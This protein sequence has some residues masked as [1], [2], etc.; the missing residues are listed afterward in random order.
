M[1]TQ[2]YKY[3]RDQFIDLL[4]DETKNPDFKKYR[5]YPDY[6]IYQKGLEKFPKL[7]QDV[8]PFVDE[9]K[10]R[11][12]EE[13]RYNAIHPSFFERFARSPLGLGAIFPGLVVD[14]HS[15]DWQKASLQGSIQGAL[16]LTT[17]GKLPFELQDYDLNPLE[18]IFSGLYSLLFPLDA[19]TMFIGGG[20][21]GL[22]LKGA[23]RYGTKKVIPKM[24]SKNLL[25]KKGL[26]N[27]ASKMAAKYGLDRKLAG[28]VMEHMAGSMGNFM[29]YEGVK[30]GFSATSSGDSWMNGFMK[31]A[32]HGAMLGASLGFTGGIM[33]HANKQLLFMRNYKNFQRGKGGF[34]GY[35]MGKILSKQQKSTLKKMYSQNSFKN[36]KKSQIDSRIAWTGKYGQYAAEV[37]TFTGFG[38]AE[39]WYSTGELPNVER[40]MSDMFVNAGFIGA[41]KYGQNR[42]ARVQ[43]SIGTFRALYE[44]KYAEREA[45]Y[46]KNEKSRKNVRKNAG[47]DLTK[48]QEK[49][50]DE[51][52]EEN[53]INRAE[54]RKEAETIIGE[55]SDLEA[56]L[57]A[58]NKIIANINA[59]TPEA[60]LD[61]LNKIKLTELPIISKSLTEA[62]GALEKAKDLGATDKQL[63]EF[64]KDIVA[65]EESIEVSVK[66]QAER[67]SERSVGEQNIF[68]ERQQQA[69]TLDIKTLWIPDKAN[70]GKNK[71]VTI[72]ELD[73][74]SSDALGKAIEAKQE[75]L[76]TGQEKLATK[77]AEKLRTGEEL[78]EAKKN[79]AELDADVDAKGGAKNFINR[80]KDPSKKTFIDIAEDASAMIVDWLRGD[81]KLTSGNGKT[82]ADLLNFVNKTDPSKITGKD[83]KRFAE[84]IGDVQGRFEGTLSDIVN[85]FNHANQQGLIK[86]YPLTKK[87]AKDLW[88]KNK[89]LIAQAGEKVK[90]AAAEVIE[91]LGGKD[92]YD[93]HMVESTKGDTE[94]NI[95]ARLS[96]KEGIGLRQQELTNLKPENIVKEGDNYKI[97][98]STKE[99]KGSRAREIPITKKMYQELK[100]LINSKGI[101]KGES[102]FRKTVGKEIME[103]TGTGKALISKG[104]KRPTLDTINRKKAESDV[105]TKVDPD[106]TGLSEFGRSLLDMV[107]GHKIK[108]SDRIYGLTVSKVKRDKLLLNVRKLVDGEI[109]V[110]EFE[111][112]NNRIV[113]GKEGV[114]KPAIKLSASQKKVLRVQSDKEIE[115]ESTKMEQM[116]K[117]TSLTN[118][119]KNSSK[120]IDGQS[121]II[122]KL[123]S[124]RD[125]GIITDRQ[126]NAKLNALSKKFEKTNKHGID[127][128]TVAEAFKNERVEIKQKAPYPPESPAQESIRYVETSKERHK[129]LL[130]NPKEMSKYDTNKK[131]QQQAVKDKELV[132]DTL[133]G[134]YWNKDKALE[135]VDKW[136]KSHE[137]NLKLKPEQTKWDKEWL[138]NY[139]QV[140]ETLTNID[141]TKP[142]KYGPTGKKIDVET[143]RKQA[144]AIANDA[145]RRKYE[146]KDIID[147]LGKDFKGKKIKNLT[148]QDLLDYIEHVADIKQ[149]G[150]KYT[151]LKSQKVK[152]MKII[153]E[154]DVSLDDLTRMIQSLGI[155]DG[156]LDSIDNPKMLNRLQSMVESGFGKADMSNTVTNQVVD[157]AEGAGALGL[158]TN[159]RKIWYP[160]TELLYRFGGE[161]GRKIADKLLDFDVATIRKRRWATE[162][163][164]KARAAVKKAGFRASEDYMFMFMETGPKWKGQFTKREL[165]FIEMLNAKE[166]NPL[167]I[168][169]DQ[170]RDMYNMYWGELTKTLL[171]NTPKAERKNALK[172]LTKKHVEN[173]FTRRV[174]PKVLESI[175]LE[176][177]PIYGKLLKDNVNELA[178][179]KA[180]ELKRRK[181]E[182]DNSYN[183]RKRNLKESYNNYFK[184]GAKVSKTVEKEIDKIKGD[185]VDFFLLPQTHIKLG[186]LNERV[187]TLDRKSKIKN[188]RGKLVEVDSY[189]ESFD[190]NVGHYGVGMSK[191]L[192]TL[193]F[194]PEFTDLGKKFGYPGIKKNLFQLINPDSK[195]KNPG[196]NSEWAMYIRDALGEQL[197]INS[198]PKRRLAS[199]NARFLGKLSTLS[200]AMGLSSPTSG[201]KNLAIG[202]PRSI[203]HFGFSNTVKALTRFMADGEELQK[204]DLNWVKEYGSKQLVMEAQE[205]PFGLEKTGLT[206][207]RL[208]NF[209][210][211]TKTEGLNRIVS[212]YAGHMMFQSTLSAYKG[213]ASKGFLDAISRTP[214]GGKKEIER[215]WREVWKLSKK[216]MDFLKDTK[217]E[218]LR[219]GPNKE[220]MDWITIKVQHYSHVS[221]QGSTS[222]ALL[223]KW[224]SGQYTR[225]LTLFQRMAWSTTTDIAQNYIMPIVKTGNAMP[226][227][228]AMIGHTL[229]GA[230]LY[231]FYKMV[232]GQEKPLQMSDEAWQKVMPNLWRS[233]FFGLFGELANPHTSPIYDRKGS[234]ANMFSGDAVVARSLLEPVII[235]NAL[236]LAENIPIALQGLY[237]QHPTKFWH[238]AMSDVANNSIVIV[239]Q[240]ARVKNN[241][242]SAHIISHNKFKGVN[243]EFMREKGYTYPRVIM[244]NA[245]T[246]Y[247]KDLKAAFWKGNKAE[248]SRSYWNA[249]NYLVTELQVQNFSPRAAHKKARQMIKSS[250]DTMHPIQHS[251]ERNGRQVSRKAEYLNWLYKK[252]R[253]KYDEILKF[254][255]E[256]YYMMRRYENVVLSR[257]NFEHYSVF[258]G[259]DYRNMYTPKFFG[260]Y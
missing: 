209:N 42:F 151:K 171:E 199:K 59:M 56:N 109:T 170:I 75:K 236:L 143:L 27:K 44:K 174:N 232:L 130:K 181:G 249:Y 68:A 122:D 148:T 47:E 17:K 13:Q 100:T 29:V 216:E 119:V 142:Q 125:N 196:L 2:K 168:A 118:L 51:Q 217:F 33:G 18:E 52:M 194:F 189:V 82:I 94:L 166:E 156:K 106:G 185:I 19:A 169:K 127:F 26:E 203:G 50:L 34:E 102:I 101:K 139:K 20:Y 198:D 132:E 136:I 37:G 205:L 167:N 80:Q 241:L 253:K 70:P 120:I 111:T 246:P 22:A 239:G 53:E 28:T 259:R 128:K 175:A 66:E 237:S 72:E 92:K 48:E 218:N 187:F 190:A 141:I 146:L 212:S 49:K 260:K 173:Y 8:A 149:H 235:R 91:D 145:G 126:F 225:P 38:A 197:G 113:T 256:Y 252:D 215:M 87:Q 115:A 74:E 150:V 251:F 153:N 244:D 159:R 152:T 206:M 164:G 207:E 200:A 103:I 257:A 213:Q 137:K 191:Y 222:T 45:E 247:Y 12:E 172:Y 133:K 240:L 162:T 73:L 254:E 179:A 96:G 255:R 178:K 243:K 228:R 79:Q 165:K 40:L 89:E 16:E 183:N 36:W 154:R 192:A 186:F 24:V 144:Y 234:L 98:L 131:E 108:W 23:V 35:G 220:L 195:S 90:G 81:P 208:F 201:L 107:M 123:K 88:D 31:G 176:K 78:P 242:S 105:L 227:M 1:A 57:G 121:K 55:F 95:G 140:R 157:L 61:Y 85:F 223:P 204:L 116:F 114:S 219:E 64:E 5:G 4:Q 104:A 7:A 76:I 258:A 250:L 41:L 138:E 62:R 39:H 202:I 83:I 129:D 182:D 11:R 214:I 65:I 161:H 233:E 14:E 193:K 210:L 177:G 10:I 238:Q 231:G 99:G 188:K 63:R 211:M 6:Y 77:I 117:N 32:G 84:H 134:N 9:E 248:W 112:S 147:A 155:K 97:K 158:L 184:K 124:D 71:K 58:I 229:S 86:K 60:A 245:R 221:T 43:E 54:V 3:T 224:M 67:M 163:M 25:L 230:A 93:I 180:K 69:D 15:Y 30:G 110:K 135:L 160:L 226:L 46:E 21:G